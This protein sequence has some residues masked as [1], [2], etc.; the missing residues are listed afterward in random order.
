MKFKKLILN[1]FG[2]YR[3][4]HEIQ[5]DTENRNT[6][7]ILIG[8]LN[9][10]GKTTI[11]DAIK[12]ALYGKFADTNSGEKNAYLE[13]V[14]KYINRDNKY[15]GAYV[16]LEIETSS[17]DENNVWGV[18]R[19]WTW[20]KNYSNIRESLNVYDIDQTKN[21]KKRNIDREEQWY[22][23]IQEVVPNQIS[24]LFF[25]DGEKIEEFADPYKASILLKT[26]VSSLFGI[27]TLERLQK[28][29]MVFEKKIIKNNN[30]EKNFSNL[31]TLYEEIE[32]LNNK[33]EQLNDKKQKLEDE[34]EE[35][36]KKENINEQRYKKIGGVFA[37]KRDEIYRTKEEK[38]KELEGLK[39]ELIEEASGV[40]PLQ[41]TKN[42]LH[43]VVVQDKKEKES[44]HI[45]KV[46]ETI[47]E[48]DKELL[49]KIK[50]MEINNKS[51]E[52]IDNYLKKDIKKRESNILDQEY[53]HNS[54]D[55]SDQL[56]HVES[57]LHEKRSIVKELSDRIDQL[58]MEIE[59]IQNKL[60]N[61]PPEE[62]LAPIIE[63]KREI[64]NKKNRLT[65]ELRTIEEE[66]KSKSFVHE[67]KKRE[68]L[69]KAHTIFSERVNVNNENRFLE[70]SASSRDTIDE[71]KRRLIEKNIRKI[72]RYILESFQHLLR[73]ENFI[74]N[75]SID[76]ETFT[77]K[78]HTENG[79]LITTEKLSAGERQL[80]ATAMLWGLAR[81]SG[82]PL[83][84][85]ID[86]PLG[87]LDSLHR[88]NLVNLYFPNASHQVI[89][90]STDEEFDG[91]YY[92]MIKPY[93]SREYTLQYSDKSKS[94]IVEEG[95]KL[96]RELV[97]EY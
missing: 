11:L 86:T 56:I 69:N 10:A 18:Q 80:L 12:F 91:E 25:F 14:K 59:D 63:E 74:Y 29:L 71:F 53:L 51:T 34:I 77:L 50:A 78:L 32:Y 5:L 27:N 82:K 67:K 36:I 30:K 26:A 35:T 62:K 24:S 48:R 66:I 75:L 6:P 88:E 44:K 19:F 13:T 43:Q 92:E 39:E 55:A 17:G 47:K 23:Y 7:I 33:I 38:V 61:M 1:N 97:N 45:K 8:G 89:L 87:R 28:D 90:L 84:T 9:G 65:Q 76:T 60:Y 58:K 96:K 4:K 42:Q 49:Q 3:G 2:L 68:Y 15:E 81:A 70:Y 94:T 73:K 79:E 16:E 95:Y 57:I 83:P 40:L 31:Q 21:L 72:E 64:N 20:T 22:E 37:E 85:I 93:I 46:I 54:T 52:E 41:I